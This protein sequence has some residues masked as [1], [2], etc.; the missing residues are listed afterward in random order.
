MVRDIDAEEDSD[1]IPSWR[2]NS[3]SK[4]TVNEKL[5]M[6]QRKWL[7]LLLQEYQD[8]FKGKPGKPMPLNTLYT[9]LMIVL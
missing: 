3:D 7:E 8:V 9:T 1:D 5:T 6:E 4:V 2:E